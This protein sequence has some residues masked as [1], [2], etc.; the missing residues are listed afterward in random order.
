SFVPV[1][2]MLVPAGKDAEQLEPPV[3]Q[4]IPAGLLVTLPAPAPLFFSVSSTGCVPPWELVTWYCPAP[5]A[6]SNRLTSAVYDPVCG[7][8]KVIVAVTASILSPR[9]C[10]LG[11]CTR[12]RGANGV[13]GPTSLTLIETLFP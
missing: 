7:A 8:V 2:V 1:S 4:S 11:A 9:D 12:S 10:P 3:P 13:F 6:L 5:S